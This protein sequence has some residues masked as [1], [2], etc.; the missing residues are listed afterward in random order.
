MAMAQAIPLFTDR[1]TTGVGTTREAPGPGATVQ[2]TVTGTGALAATVLIDVGNISGSWL[3]L[4]TLS[5]SGNDAVTD[6]L[7]LDAHWVYIRANCTT[8]TGTGATL[9][10]VMGTRDRN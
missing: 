1:T 10:V 2:A 8:L 9:N 5:L 3:N 7:A 4:G 6:G